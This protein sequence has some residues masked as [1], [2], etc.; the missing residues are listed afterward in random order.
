MKGQKSLSPNRTLELKLESENMWRTFKGV[1]ENLPDMGTSPSVKAQDWESSWR[2][3]GTKRRPSTWRVASLGDCRV[4]EK[5]G[6]ITRQGH[7]RPSK[8]NKE[9]EGCYKC[10]RSH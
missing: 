10:H 1:R 8:S 4:A 7:F 9:L 6:N 2:V 5:V 3:P